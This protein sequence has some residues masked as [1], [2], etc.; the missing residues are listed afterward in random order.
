MKTRRQLTLFLDPV[1][2][3]PLEI[4]RKAFNPAQHALIKAHATLCREDELE[5]LDLVIENIAK[6]QREPFTLEF[7]APIRFSE[8]NGVLLPAIGDLSPFHQLRA[9]I[10]RGIFEN[11]R[12]QEPHIT[13]IHPRNASCTDAIFAQIQQA[14][15]PRTFVFSKISLIEQEIGKVWKVLPAFE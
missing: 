7:G 9:D 11:P 2:A 13:L 5:A 8:G 3:E 4:L 15:L 12:I 14:A 6:I 1:A 10:L